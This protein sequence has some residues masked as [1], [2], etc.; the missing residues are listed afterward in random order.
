MNIALVFLDIFRDI[1][2]TT[3]YTFTPCVGIFYFPWHRHQVEG[4]KSF[5][6]SSERPGQSGVNEV[7][8]ISKQQ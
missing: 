6:V 3:G 4:V 2:L 8:Q 5:I 7:A 1:Q